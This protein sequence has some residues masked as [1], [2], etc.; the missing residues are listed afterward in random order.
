MCTT[1][2]IG[3]KWHAHPLC[4]TP[5]HLAP[6]P[7]F[8]AVCPSS[9]PHHVQRAKDLALCAFGVVAM[10]VC[11]YVTVTA[12]GFHKAVGEVELEGGGDGDP[13]PTPTSTPNP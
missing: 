5:H 12:S 11:T 6:H 10:F 13:T 9:P 8:C 2:H 3:I 1:F 4:T 7:T